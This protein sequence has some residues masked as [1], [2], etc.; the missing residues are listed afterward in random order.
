VRSLY[1]Q[2]SPGNAGREF[3]SYRLNGGGMQEVRWEEGGTQRALYRIGKKNY[4]SGVKCFV[5][6]RII[7]RVK[8]VQ[9]I[10]GRMSYVVLRGRWCNNIVLIP[11]AT[12][13]DKSGGSE[14]SFNEQL[15]QVFDYFLH[16]HI[17]KSVRRF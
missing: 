1:R 14:E 6:L 12:T 16:C 5:H 15:E 17:K 8:R 9:C 7:S 13:E 11:Q 4:Q 10:S 2:R 3:A